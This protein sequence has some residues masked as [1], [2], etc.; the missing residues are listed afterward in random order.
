MPDIRGR[1]PWRHQRA[2]VQIE[3]MNHHEIV[4]QAEILDGQ[5]VSVDQAAVAVVLLW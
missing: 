5:S 3:R 1:L 2:A 4:A